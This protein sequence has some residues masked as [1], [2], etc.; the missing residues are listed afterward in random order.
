MHH[1]YYTTQ[2]IEFLYDS[3][4]SYNNITLTR[5]TTFIKTFKISDAQTN[6]YKY[7]LA[8]NITV[9]H[10][11]INLTT[12]HYYKLLWSSESFEVK[13]NIG[14]GIPIEFP[15]QRKKFKLDHK[16][17]ISL[18]MDQFDQSFF[19]GLVILNPILK[20]TSNDSLD[21]KSL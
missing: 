4:P 15:H 12:N 9:Y 21:H 6:I 14:F 19:F 8:A 16:S 5:T 7:R 20:F 17:P 3:T 10:I 13:Y 1:P 2:P 11:K 18:D